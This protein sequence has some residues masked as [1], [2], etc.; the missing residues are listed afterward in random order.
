MLCLFQGAPCLDIDAC[1]TTE[2]NIW[3]NT[4]E[5]LEEYFV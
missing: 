5:M 1:K 2:S 4:D 3:A